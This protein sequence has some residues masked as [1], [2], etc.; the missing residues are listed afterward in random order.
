[1]ERTFSLR[2]LPGIVDE[3]LKSLPVPAVWALHGPMGVGKTTFVHALCDALGV[4][5]PVSSPT[6]SL[7]NEYRT[8]EQEVIYHID[9]Y[10]V[11]GEEEARQ[12]GIEDC[13]Y[14]GAF[15]LVEWPGKAPG[16]FAPGT[17]HLHFNLVDETKRRLKINGN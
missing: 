17:I 14:S 5:D 3:L 6:F 4:T 13:L 16:L 9:L 10:R 8:G 15:C 11:S 2:E 12:A 7:V 1:M